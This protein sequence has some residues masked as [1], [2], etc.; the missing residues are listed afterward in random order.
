M[1]LSGGG[2]GAGWWGC[3]VISNR[4]RARLPPQLA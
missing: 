4:A 2:L 1:Q 3:V